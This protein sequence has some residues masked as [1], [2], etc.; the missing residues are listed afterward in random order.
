M[1]SGTNQLEVPVNNFTRLERDLRAALA[2]FKEIN[3]LTPAVDKTLCSWFQDVPFPSLPLAV[4]EMT[5]EERSALT[6]TV[7]TEMVEACAQ[8]PEKHDDTAVFAHLGPLLDPLWKELMSLRAEVLNAEF[9]AVRRRLS[10]LQETLD[11]TPEQIAETVLSMPINEA[12]ETAS[13]NAQVRL[14]LQ[15]L[16]I[17]S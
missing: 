5:G 17:I 7:L 4:M 13:E 15:V 2:V 16:G 9:E 3:D 14:V 6:V 11:A 12:I 1:V 8:A 10:D